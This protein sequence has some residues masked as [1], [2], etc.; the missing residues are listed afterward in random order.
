[1]TGALTDSD[2]DWIGA[3]PRGWSVEPVGRWFRER[4]VTVSDTDFAPLSVTMQGIVPQLEN[5][6]KTDN[7]ANRKLVRKGDFAI[8][9]RSD[10]KG[11]AGVSDRDGSV[12]VITTVLEPQGLD[13]RFT[14]QLLRSRPFQEEFYRWGHGI[15]DDLWST[16]WSDMKSIK[17]PIPPLP[18]Q[19]A[20]ADFLERETAQIDA[21][22]AKNEELIA[23]LAERRDSR[24]DALYTEAEAEGTEVPLRR[25]VASI[26]DGPFGSSL[27][28]AHYSDSGTRVIRLGNI[29]VGEFKDAD[30]AFIPNDYAASLRAH[31]AHAGDVIIAGLGD[32]RMPLGRACV[33]PQIGPAIV[34]ADC[35]RVR[36]SPKVTS[37]YLSWC[38]SSP[39]SR[40]RMALEARGT[41]RARLNTSV[42]LRVTLPVPPL[43]RQAELV[44]QFREHSATFNAA[45]KAAHDTITLARERRA[46]LISAAVT[47]KIDVGARA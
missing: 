11:S 9:S 18:E 14:H 47:G 46:A 32:E 44:H 22:I 5:V 30:Q 10:R 45:L 6:A 20:I 36:P 4:R 38:L 21:F 26:C 15:V 43:A 16:K 42:V 29:G 25:V 40:G 28:S 39:A 1:M 2:G 8:N 37:E 7:N 33:L 35:Y 34:K 31:S 13:P 41:T 23:L 3:I 17:I 24:W 12:S 19:R 27:T